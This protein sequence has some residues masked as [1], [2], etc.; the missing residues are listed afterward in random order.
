[1]AHQ[2]FHFPPLITPMLKY[3]DIVAGFAESQRNYSPRQRLNFDCVFRTYTAANSERPD[4]WAHRHED[5]FQECMT[6]IRT[7][8]NPITET[9]CCRYCNVSSHLVK[10][11]PMLGRNFATTDSKGT[12]KS[13]NNHLFWQ[14]PVAD[15][16]ISLEFNKAFCFCLCCAQK[17]HKCTFCKRGSHGFACREANARLQTTI[18][19]LIQTSL[20]LTAFRHQLTDHPS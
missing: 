15:G 16:K 7:L 18:P 1:M 11:W 19:A 2:T 17:I 9:Q 13:T 20:Q 12:K 14:R 10:E 8:M 4:L 5:T 6:L 3:F